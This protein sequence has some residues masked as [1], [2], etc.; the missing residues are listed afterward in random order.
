MY[1]ANVEK[2]FQNFRK[3]IIKK[4]YQQ[5]SPVLEHCPSLDKKYID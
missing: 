4:I 1:V 5:R 2:K 3:K